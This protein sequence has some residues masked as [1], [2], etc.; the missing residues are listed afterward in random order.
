MLQDVVL[1]EGRLHLVEVLETSGLG[2]TQTKLN[3]RVHRGPENIFTT[4]APAF[5]IS[6]MPFAWSSK[7]SS[8]VVM[9]TEGITIRLNAI[10]R[11]SRWKDRSR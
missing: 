2:V 7:C 4:L 8:E 9:L 6:C 11:F 3:C 1:G 10:I 5:R